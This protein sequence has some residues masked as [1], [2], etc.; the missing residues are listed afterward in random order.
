MMV[1]HIPA[2]VAN[3]IRE[4]QAT[5][6]PAYVVGGAVRDLL[7]DR[8]PDDFDIATAA[9][10][11]EVVALAFRQGWK[12]VDQLGEN[13]GVVLVVVAGHLVEVATFRGESYGEDAHRPEAV[14]FTDELIIDLARRDFT[15]NAMALDLDGRLIDPFG[16]L[17][18]IQKKIIRAV[19]LPGK[20]FAEDGLRM[21]RACR[22]AA[23][24]GFF[25]DLEVLAAIPPLLERVR[26]LSRQRVKDELNWLLVAPYPQLG[27][28]PLVATGLAGVECRVKSGDGSMQIPILPELTA[29]YQWADD[30]GIGSTVW[31]QLKEFVASVPADLTL[32]WAA[33][34]YAVAADG[35]R[36]ADQDKSTYEQE[37]AQKSAA[38][39]ATILYRFEFGAKF[40]ERVCWLIGQRNLFSQ[41]GQEDMD[42]WLR[43]EACSGRYRSRQQ[44]AEAVEQ[45]VAFCQGFNLAL[46]PT[47]VNSALQNQG[48]E[49]IQL[50][51]TM[52]VGTVD[53]RCSIPSIQELLPPGEAVGPLLK[54]LLTQVQARVIANEPAAI[55]TAAQS[56]LTS[57]SKPLVK[58]K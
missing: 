11:D 46:G 9:R 37:L 32:R 8:T 55:M 21:F 42:R 36:Q 14:W 34:L 1:E 18:D 26:G 15:M 51:R 24:L 56:W 54:W 40:R 23:E 10:P 41:L 20:R 19:G 12:T 31:T 27:L 33:L 3:L 22:F 28:E 39:A 16:G 35:Q 5:G 17:T 49:W 45:L 4:I 13:F 29:L 48:Q 7:L 50:A 30:Q 43:Q 2:A 25:L 6:R 57:C 47:I 38:L 52:P 53:L 58:E 44:L